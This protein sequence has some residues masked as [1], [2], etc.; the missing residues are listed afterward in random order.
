VPAQ[1]GFFL[2]QLLLQ[3][4]GIKSG[5]KSAFGGDGHLLQICRKSKIQKAAVKRLFWL[6]GNEF[7]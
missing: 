4:A 5:R 2:P 7:R 1:Q 6:G 3:Q